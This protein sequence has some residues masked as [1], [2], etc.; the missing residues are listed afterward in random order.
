MKRIVLPLLIAV[1]A[2]AAEEAAKKQSYCRV[3]SAD[4]VVNA[5]A[6]L[7]TSMQSGGSPS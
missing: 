5:A 2:T 1:A 4:C 7:F 6:D 3:G